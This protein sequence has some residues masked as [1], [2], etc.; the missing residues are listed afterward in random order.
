MRGQNLVR[1]RS[2]ALVCR[3]RGRGK[4]AEVWFEPTSCTEIV[5]VG[6]GVI[7]IILGVT[8]LEDDA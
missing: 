6:V 5:G 3:R 7:T 1:V 4:N 2:T 8:V